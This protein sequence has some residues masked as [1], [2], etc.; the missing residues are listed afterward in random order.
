MGYNPIKDNLDMK[1]T[2]N[3]HVVPGVTANTYILIDEDG[4]TLIDTGMPGSEKKILAYLSELGKN[5]GDVKRIVLTHSDIDHVG[6]LAVLA[7]ESGA[8]TYASKIEA[9]AIATG[10]PSRQ[11]HLSGFSFRRILFSLLSPFFKAKAFQIDKMLTDGQTLP[12]IGGLRVVETPGHTPGHVSLYAANAKVLFCGDSMISDETGLQE[13]RPEATWDA[14]M[15]RK[16]V[17]KQAELGATIVC[18][19][20]GPVIWEAT[21]RF[22]IRQ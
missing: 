19:G 7:R 12:V 2:D 5:A 14:E 15:A 17:R 16:S 4:L 6:G 10:K 11:V 3:I 18:A 20:H 13:S 21:G 1:I 9:K 22:P 8:G